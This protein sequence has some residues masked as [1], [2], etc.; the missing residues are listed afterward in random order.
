MGWEWSFRWR[1][2]SLWRLK[3][4]EL[5]CILETERKTILSKCCQHGREWRDNP[6]VY[7]V[8]HL[9]QRGCS[10][11]GHGQKPLNNSWP[12]WNTAAKSSL[13]VLCP[14]TS[15]KAGLHTHF[16][17]ISQL[18]PY[19]ANSKSSWQSDITGPGPVCIVLLE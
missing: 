9:V 16:I 14:A 10:I 3:A 15:W 18:P 6:T 12:R 17:W 4:K 8:R 19:M 13:V 1:E 2:Q 7:L 5:W 11:S